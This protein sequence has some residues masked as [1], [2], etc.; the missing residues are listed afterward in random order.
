MDISNRTVILVGPAPSSMGGT[1][2]APAPAHA[3]RHTLRTADTPNSAAITHKRLF[4]TNL[5]SRD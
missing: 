3:D 2:G 1:L 5:Q 4:T